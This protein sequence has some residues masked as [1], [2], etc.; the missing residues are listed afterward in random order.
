MAHAR[1]GRWMMK[2]SK[3]DLS[4]LRVVLIAAV[5]LPGVVHAVPLSQAAASCQADLAK[6]LYVFQQKSLKAWAKC[7]DAELRGET[8]DDAVRDAAI[9]AAR[10][11][12]V[13]RIAKRCADAEIF[14][15][16]PGGTGFASDCALEAGAPSPDEA[17]CAALPAADASQLGACLACWKT[18]EIGRLLSAIYPCLGAQIPDGA[19]LDCG[20]AP[21][22]CPDPV[23]ARRDVACLLATSRATRAWM[24]AAEKARAK[25]LDR[26]RAGKSA[27]PCP[28]AAASAPLQKKAQKAL[29]TIAR[30]CATLPLFWDVCP[31]DEAGACEAT[32]ASSAELAGCVVDGAA[33]VAERMLCL[34]YPGADADGLSCAAPGCVPT[35]PDVCNGLDDDCD[36]ETVDGA[37]DPAIATPTP[38]DD[39]VESDACEEG[40]AI[41]TEGALACT[42]PGDDD[43]ANDAE[44][45]GGC[46]LPCQA[47][48]ATAA[49]CSGGICTPTCEL[50]WQDC[51]GEPRNGC[52]ADRDGEALCAAAVDLGDVDGDDGGAGVARTGFGGAWF[53]VNML[54]NDLG[55]DNPAGV[56]S[57]TNPAG[58][59]FEVCA[60]CATCGAARFKCVTPA[61][62][63]SA[64]IRL[65]RADDTPG[66]EDV[67]LFIEVAF[68][69]AAAGSCGNWSLDV[70]GAD[71]SDDCTCD[72]TP[73]GD[74]CD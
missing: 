61:A 20:V 13:A 22:A 21:S 45:C 71:A 55:D 56:V 62:G 50:G 17:A 41:C 66:A 36:P 54:E 69:D 6:A 33:Q 7:L 49:A 28:D 51:D 24:L 63:G 57:L 31:I 65:G 52:E 38:C 53:R 4:R 11:K 37:A 73:N 18:A 27:G 25:C 14:D 72:G 10:T 46:G 40:I 35:G 5:L 15:A 2:S 34:Q 9:D 42:D 23:T 70:R 1:L 59:R 44:H 29:T 47:N 67:L 48:H 60:Y 74:D 16:P 43:I 26:V 19:G 30:S 39:P 68:V 32:I 3:L 64:T 12:A 58:A 8:C